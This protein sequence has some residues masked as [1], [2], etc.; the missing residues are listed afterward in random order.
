MKH[1]LSLLLFCTLSST[2][3]AQRGAEAGF[4]VGA[5]FYFGD[6]NT[7]FN[8]ANPGLALN[9]YGRFNFDERMAIKF[10]LSYGRISGDDSRSD[11]AFQRA[12]NLDFFSDVWDGT[13]QLEFNFFPYIHGSKDRYFTP[14]IFTGLSAFRYSPKTKLDGTTYKLQEYGTEGQG[15]GSEY[16][17]FNLGI[18]Y[19]GGL[20]WDLSYYWSINVEVSGRFLFTDYLD[21][22]SEVY[23]DLAALGILRGPEAA[24]LS[25]RSDPDAPSGPIGRAGVQ[26]G[27]SKNNDSYN[28]ALV[29]LAYYFGRV[30]CPPI[31]RPHVKTKSKKR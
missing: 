27:N 14:Y 12:R 17:L 9:G 21:D 31:S 2:I 3:F 7:Q 22:V 19:G 10:G 16:S 4:N 24:A 30:K 11:N 5:A 15:I 8:L 20:K 25:D 1:L 13:L 18:A 29:G 28:F 6:L 26:R 23:P